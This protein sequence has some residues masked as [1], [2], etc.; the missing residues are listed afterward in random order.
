[1]TIPTVHNL[2]GKRADIL[3]TLVEEAMSKV[4]AAATDFDPSDTIAAVEGFIDGLTKLLAT[5]EPLY[6][7]AYCWGMDELFRA[8]VNHRH[9]GQARNQALDLQKCHR[10]RH[11]GRAD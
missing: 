9:C 6:R 1:M 4:M 8:P 11:A 7:A 5:N 10:A 2:L 3:H